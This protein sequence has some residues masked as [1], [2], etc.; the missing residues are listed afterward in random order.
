MTR[1]QLPLKTGRL[2]SFNLAISA[3]AA[4]AG[5][6]FAAV[7]TFSPSD[8]AQGPINVTLSLDQAKPAGAGAE[9]GKNGGLDT[10]DAVNLSSKG[11]GIVP[12]S[13]PA[14]AMAPLTLGNG[15]TFTSALKTGDDGQYVYRDMF[16]GRN[17]T[18]LVINAPETEINLLVGFPSQSPKSVAGIEYTPPRDAGGLPLASILDITVLPDG[19]LGAGQPIMSFALQTSNGSQ[20]FALPENMSGKGLWLRVAGPAGFEKIAVGDFKI[21]QSA[22]ARQ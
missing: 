19:Q 15:A 6:I 11:N 2:S 10:I 9:F 16:D 13:A 18:F 20:T 17:E 8:S 1:S 5:V 14:G 7:Q 3:F 22:S 21:L 12:A 4:L